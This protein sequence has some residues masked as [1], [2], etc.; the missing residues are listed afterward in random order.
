M[1][2]ELKSKGWSLELDEFTQSMAETMEDGIR[3][4]R[5]LRSNGAILKTA[6]N[7]GLVL[8]IE[9]KITA[10]DVDTFKP[11]SFINWAAGHIANVYLEAITIPKE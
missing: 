3:G 5:G 2:Y 8:S 9:P 6:I 10:D 11:P 7:V 4:F 1:K